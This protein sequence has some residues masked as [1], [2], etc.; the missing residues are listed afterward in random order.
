MPGNH[1]VLIGFHNSCDAAARRCTDNFGMAQVG[2][3]VHHDSEMFETAANLGADGGASLAN[4]TR[5]DHRVET[6]EDCCKR[7]DEF[8]YLITEHIHGLRGVEI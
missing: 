3:I 8:P 5:E 4:A 7:T 6:T 2:I 1:Q